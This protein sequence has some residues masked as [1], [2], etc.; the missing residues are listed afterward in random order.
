MS[1]GLFNVI[2]AIFVDN[3]LSAAKFNDQ[4]KLKERLNNQRFFAD[5]MA[6]LTRLIWD[7]CP[8]LFQKLDGNHAVK[9]TALWRGVMS[10]QVDELIDTAMLMQ[11]TREDFEKL[12]ATKDFTVLLS[13]L[14]VSDE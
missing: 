13:H 2:V 8:N 10:T 9:R 4:Q 6:E 1:F 7:T 5:K 14:D 3:I 11:I 12:R